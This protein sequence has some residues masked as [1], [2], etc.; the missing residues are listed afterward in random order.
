MATDAAADDVNDD[1]DKSCSAVYTAY[2]PLLQAT[3]V[4]LDNCHER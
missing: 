1:A 3:V 2:V 4:V